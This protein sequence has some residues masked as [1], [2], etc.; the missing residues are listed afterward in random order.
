MDARHALLG[1]LID[2]APLFPPASLPLDEALAE[3]ERARAGAH[4]WLLGRFVVP[5]SRLAELGNADLR[6]SVV[7]DENVEL[8]DPR[9]EA[10][11]V[12]PGVEPPGLAPAEVY[13]EGRIEPAF[14]AKVRCGGA[15]VPRVEELAGFIRACRE[16]RVVFKATAGLHH[17]LPAGGQHGFLN[18]LAAC[19]FGD[20]EEALRHDSFELDADSFRWGDRVAGPEELARVR[21]E[22]FAGFGTCSF[23]EPVDELQALGI[24]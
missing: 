9:I 24:L 22:L 20:E 13:L 16:Q 1:R 14:R 19:V 6:L 4:A 7:F 18:L 3:H 11:E 17:A 21:D 5:A 10:V 8:L 15:R 23:D 12:P 2:H